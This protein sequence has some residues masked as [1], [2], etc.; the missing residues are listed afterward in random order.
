MNLKNLR[1]LF[2]GE[3]KTDL[4]IKEISSK[5][6][7]N[8]FLDLD[9]KLHFEK[10]SQSEKIEWFDEKENS[11]PLHIALIIDYTYRSGAI[12]RRYITIRQI[13]Q[14]M[15]GDFRLYSFCH[16]NEEPRTF[17]LSKVSQFI[18]AYTGNEIVNAHEYIKSRFNDDSVTHLNHILKHYKNE[19]M[20][21]LFIGNSD[22]KMDN[23]ELNIIIDYFNSISDFEY[24]RKTILKE[25]KQMNCLLFDFEN[26]LD[27]INLS[28][29]LESKKHLLE[30]AKFVVWSNDEAHPNEVSGFELMVQ[31]LLD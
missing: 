25:L 27:K 18:D 15:D 7:S 5:F 11:K 16:E 28:K 14:R 10:D 26:A 20:V 13:S 12:G 29:S 4:R 2:F 8:V 9:V 19:L 23:A 3:S 30:T 21:L 17:L 22:R 31:Y 6:Q 1:K 24:E